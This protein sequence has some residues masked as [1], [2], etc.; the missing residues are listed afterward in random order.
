[1]KSKPKNSSGYSGAPLPKKLGIKPGHRLVLLH[2]PTGFENSLVGLPDDV[3]LSR[4]MRGKALFDVIV[5]FCKNDAT[6]Q[7]D[8]L[9]AK[10]RLTEPGGLWIAWPKKA[11]GI[12]TD[13]DDGKVRAFG[14]QS[15]LVDNKVCA[16]DQTWSGLRFVVRRVDRK[17]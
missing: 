14:L 7:K 4:S 10:G 2:A 6:L 5:L 1:M 16:I 8:F 12:V 17:E 3:K 9:K 11:S 15:G 13:I